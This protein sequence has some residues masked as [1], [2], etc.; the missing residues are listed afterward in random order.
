MTV[1]DVTLQ[2]YISTVAMYAPTGT[3]EQDRLHSVGNGKGKLSS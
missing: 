1:L 3:D 2:L